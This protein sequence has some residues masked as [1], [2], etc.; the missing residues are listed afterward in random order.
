MKR[1]IILLALFVLVVAAS[2]CTGDQWSTNKTFSGNGLTFVYPGTWSNEDSNQSGSIQN[3]TPIASVGNS[4]YSFMVASLAVPQAVQS[5]SDQFLQTI[6]PSL[7]NYPNATLASNKTI[8]VDG[9]SG[10]QVNYNDVKG[11]NSGDTT[12]SLVV[13]IK[14]SKAWLAS[15]GSKTNDTATLDRILST[16]QTT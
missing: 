4:E 2:G 15:Y 1:I 6:T 13:W 9:V 3:S 7:S 16:V 14:N 8:S 11:M 10:I 5:N 12:L